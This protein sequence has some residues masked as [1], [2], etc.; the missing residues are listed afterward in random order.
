MYLIR[1]KHS[2]THTYIHTYIH[3]STPAY[4]LLSLASLL[5]DPL[6]RASYI[7]SE[8]EVYPAARNVVAIET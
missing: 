1:N 6:Y 5:S 3:T 4:L 7:V 2:L 8:Q